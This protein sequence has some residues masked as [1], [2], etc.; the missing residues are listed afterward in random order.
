MTEPSSASF[1]TLSAAANVAPEEIPQKMPSLRASAREASMA[2]ASLTVRILCGTSRSR[3]FGTKSGVQ[4][5]ILCG[6]KGLPDSSAA[7]SGSHAMIFT[8]GR[9][10]LIIWPAPVSVPPVPQ[11]VT[12]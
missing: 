9:A 11:P 1:A 2:S 3:T 6:V 7:P 12:K 4:P 5:W 10:S 8:S